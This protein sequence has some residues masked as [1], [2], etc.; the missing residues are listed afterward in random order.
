MTELIK[1]TKYHHKE[2]NLDVEYCGIQRFQGKMYYNFYCSEN[3]LFYWF[4]PDEVEH[5]CNFDN[6][7]C[8]VC[9]KTPF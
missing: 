2:L 3:E 7:A 8:P 4:N 1:G 5:V 6:Y 9:G